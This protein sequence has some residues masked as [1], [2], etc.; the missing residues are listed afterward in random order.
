MTTPGVVRIAFPWRHY[1][2]GEETKGY[3]RDKICTIRM[4]L[5]RAR[6]EKHCTACGARIPKGADH[7]TPDWSPSYYAIDVDCDVAHTAAAK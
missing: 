3:G 4:R 1:P 5:K 6:V 2:D 7:Y